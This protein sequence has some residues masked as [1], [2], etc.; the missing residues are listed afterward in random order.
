[1]MLT[2]KF[3][4]IGFWWIG[5][6]L[7]LLVSCQR[8]DQPVDAENTSSEA[9]TLTLNQPM[10]S[11]RG[12]WYSNQPTDDA[13]RYKYSGGLGTYPS[14]HYPFAV[15]A[16]EVEKTFFCYGGTDA[17]GTTLLHMV[18]HYDHATG[19]VPKPT[20]LLDKRTD[21]AHDNP[22]LNLDEQGYVWVFSTSHGTER[23]SYIHRSTQPYDVTHFERVIATKQEDGQAV[24]LDNFSYLQMY[25]VPDAGFLGLFTHYDRN[26][27]PAHPNRPRRTTA[28]MTSADGVRWSEWRDIGAIAEGHYQTSGQQ[29]QKVATA[30]NYHPAGQQERGLNLRT[31]LYYLETS[32]FGRTWQAADGAAVAL[33][34]TEVQTPALVHDYE[35]EGKLVY[36]HDVNFDEAERPIILFLISNGFASGPDN[37]PRAWHTAHWNG[38]EWDIRPLTTSDNN[39]DVGSLY[40]EDGSWKVIGP[41]EVGPQPYN[42]GGEVAMWTSEDQGSTWRRKVLT[43]GSN[44]NHSYVR[45]PLRAH[46]DFYAFWA[47]GHG[48]QKSASTLH[49]ANQAG[50]VYR[51]PTTL[52]DPTSPEAVTPVAVQE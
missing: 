4:L 13:Y 15:Y 50:M 35:A 17:D 11:Y 30:F 48:R 41:T 1:M 7:G 23:P 47:D 27:L 5:G 29:G 36:I 25:H 26:V 38:T 19:T 16:P 45:R 46:P 43:R 32:D 31:N 24:P 20:L 49:F 44:R 9:D 8:T 28:F 39:Y 52:N 3:L 37:G 42:T 34:L 12:I 2:Q 14:N 10:S 51:L 22:V 40:V 33:P 18:S 21:D 6:A